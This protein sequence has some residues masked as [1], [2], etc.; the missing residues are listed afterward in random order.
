MARSRSGFTLIELLIVVVIIGILAA[1]A[2][3]KFASSKERAYDA[4][5]VSDLRSIITASE[6]YYA[7]R[8]IYPTDMSALDFTLSPH[9]TVTKFTLG[10][11]DGIQSLHIHIEHDNSTHYYHAEYPAESGFEKRNK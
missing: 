2:I 4:T 11:K 9:V 8:L 10:T 3:P 5:A 6:A 1:I 7:D